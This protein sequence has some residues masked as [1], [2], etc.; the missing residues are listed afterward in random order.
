MEKYIVE[1]NSHIPPIVFGRF[2]TKI[3]EK[4]RISYGD[5]GANNIKENVVEIFSGLLN[6]IN[7]SNL[8]NNTLLVGKVQSGKT[9]NLELLTALAFDNGYKLLVIY[10]GY[11]DS[12]LKQT[13]G[14]FRKTFDAPDEPDFDSDCPAIFSTAEDADSEITEEAWTELLDSKPVIFISMKRPVAMGKVNETLKKMDLSKVKTFIIDDEGDQAS[15]N[16]ARDKENNASATYKRII[17]MKEILRDPLYLSVTAT[18]QANIYLDDYSAV[19]PASIHLIHPGVGYVGSD[20]FHLTDDNHIIE[21]IDETDEDSMSSLPESL[22]SA[23][24]YFIVASAVK[25]KIETESS[26]KYSDMIIHT[27]KEVSTHKGIYT[28][29]TSYLDNYKNGLKNEDSCLDLYYQDFKDVYDVYLEDKYKKKFPFDDLKKE[30]KEIVVKAN[31][32]LKNSEGKKTQGN[33]KLKRYKIY[34]GG[35]LLQ[36]GITF[37]NLITTYFTRWANSGGNMDTNL[38]RARWFGYRERYI[39]LCKVFTTKTISE[40]F[41]NLAEIDNN[42]WEQFSEVENGSLNI[43]D[44]IID[45]EKTRQSP[46]SKTKA[47]FRRYSFYQQ[48]KKQR[49]IVYNDKDVKKN[50]SIVKEFIEGKQWVSTSIGSTIGK[51]TAVYTETSS[52]EIVSIFNKMSGIFEKKDEAIQKDVLS[53]IL[54]DRKIYVLRMQPDGHAISRSLYLNDTR[55]KALQEGRRKSDE[56]ESNYLGDAKVLIETN[57]VNIQIYYLEPCYKSNGKINVLDTKTQFVFAFYIPG[58]KPFFAKDKTL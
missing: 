43:E 46:T 29:I 12:L 33:E 44:I 47:K 18:P 50:N 16:T 14:R 58:H 30:I 32:I 21:V 24:R 39:D 35:D 41:S 57:E 7:D 9:S 22:K 1:K 28:C 55:I 5:I 6:Q 11:D 25:I 49:N 2:A 27:V 19:K 26:K 51:E 13:T 40:E 23:I 42:I 37:E 52:E 3:I 4:H 10:G 36:R 31:V 17:E 54:G 56:T 34:I 20:V 45:A 38:Q 15:L 53:K 8:S 48:W